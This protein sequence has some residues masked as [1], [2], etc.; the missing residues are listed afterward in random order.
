MRDRTR[1]TARAI[2]CTGRGGIRYP[3]LAGGGATVA[4]PEFSRRGSA[5]P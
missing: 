3:F 1:P 4:D 5:N 2:A